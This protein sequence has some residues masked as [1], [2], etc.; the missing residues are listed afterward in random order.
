MNELTA[1]QLVELR[2]RLNK[3]QQELTGLLENSSEGALPVA[4]EQPIGRLSRMDAMQQ[5]SMVQANRSAARTQLELVN[6][7][8]RRISASDYGDCLACEE[9]I[10]FSRLQVKPETALCIDCQRSNEQR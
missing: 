8:L 6:A 5:Q 7:A 2:E 9:P 1:P 10:P 3:M 4:L